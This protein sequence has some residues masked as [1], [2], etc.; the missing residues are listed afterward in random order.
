MRIP[1]PQITDVY[2]GDGWGGPRAGRDM[3]VPDEVD[4]A[5]WGS[6]LPFRRC[7]ADCYSFQ[8]AGS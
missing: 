7:L 5:L 8:S 3:L 4:G 6:L 2:C 1:C